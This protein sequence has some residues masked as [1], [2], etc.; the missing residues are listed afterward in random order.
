MNTTTRIT[1]VILDWAG[2]TIDYGCYAPLDAFISA[3]MERDVEITV[4]EARAPMG[5]PKKDHIRAILAM[6]GP[7]AKWKKA[8]GADPGGKD[9]ED[10]YARFEPMLMSTIERYT[11]LVPGAADT[12]ASLRASGIKIG[13][14]TGYT[15]EMM[16]PVLREA[17]RRGYTP[18]AV[19]T[20]D[21]CPAG[22]PYPW[23]LMRNMIELKIPE[24]RTVLKIGDTLSDIAEGLA[25]GVWSAGVIEGSSE[26]GLTKQE[27]DA[28]AES[29]KRYAR[30]KVR[31]R[32]FDAGAHLV[33]DRIS[34]ATDA[35]RD[36]NEALADGAYP[37]RLEET[38]S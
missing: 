34:D 33:I 35:I 23:M 11:E 1:G 8:H 9:V 25:A 16:K 5:L 26:L 29:E 13:S 18:D 24:A 31:E 7:R 32:F 3:F 30:R 2:T 6:D 12:V 38:G 22:R 20:P 15:A 17:A 37:H 14:T 27:F 10:L 21:D 28:L 19:V 36:V 4:A